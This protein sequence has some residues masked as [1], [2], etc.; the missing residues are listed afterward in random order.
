MK[1]NRCFKTLPEKEK[2]L[3]KVAQDGEVIKSPHIG[4]RPFYTCL[5][6]GKPYCETCWAKRP[7]DD[8]KYEAYNP[9]N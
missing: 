2:R 8:M 4:E 7:C 6:C 5:T 9:Q 3:Y 1:C